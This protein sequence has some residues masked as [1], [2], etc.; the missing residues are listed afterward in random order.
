[1]LRGRRKSSSAPHP[2]CF[3]TFVPAFTA[4]NH[5]FTISLLYNPITPA[6]PRNKS[7]VRVT[8]GERVF[9]YFHVYW[10]GGRVL[11]YIQT[12]VVNYLKGA[13]HESFIQ[14]DDDT[15]LAVVCYAD[16][17]QEELGWWLQ[18]QRALL[19]GWDLLEGTVP[20][21]AHTL[22]HTLML[23]VWWWPSK[24]AEDGQRQF[25]SK[26]LL[27]FIRNGRSKADAY[28]QR[29]TSYRISKLLVRHHR[30]VLLRFV[31]A[32]CRTPCC[33]FLYYLMMTELCDCAAFRVTEKK[34]ET[35]MSSA[36][37]ARGYRQA[38]GAA[39]GSVRIHIQTHAKPYEGDKQDL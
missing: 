36:K 14:V 16:F 26:L 30:V 21:H 9:V 34:R 3:H 28:T 37:R 29:F 1:M 6:R 31:R 8:R 35:L 18:R 13:V 22:V 38:D 17:R 19:K 10:G 33:Y 20:I 11:C 7:A 24:S 2:N 4:M 15:V 25:L 12:S 32:H 23:K 5:V 39:I 27:S